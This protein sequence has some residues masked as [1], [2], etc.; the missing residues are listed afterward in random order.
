MVVA[1]GSGATT[2]CV[3]HG[4]HPLTAAE[5]KTQPS[6]DVS[7]EAFAGAVH[8][9]LLSEPSS[10][11]R[12]VRLAGVES[13]QMAR[14]VAKFRG[15]SPERGLAAVT[16]GLYLLRSGELTPRLLGD[17]GPEAL[18]GA[19]HELANAGDEGAAR[20]LYEILARVAPGPE[21]SDARQHLDAIAAWTRDAVATGGPVAAA[22]GLEHVS[23]RRRL[24]EPSAQALDESAN[25]TV[26]WFKK[27]VT[28]Q[29]MAKAARTPPVREEG[30]AAW[31][32]LQT[33]PAVLAA[34]Y[35]RDGDAAGALAAL[36]KADARPFLAKML[37][38]LET[39]IESCAESPDAQ[40]L[41]DVLRAL[42]PLTRVDASREEDDFAE[43]RELFR[44][45][46][47]GVALAAYRLDP[48]LPEAAI[49]VAAYLQELGMAEAGPAILYDAARAHTDAQTLDVA[50]SITLSSLTQES[51]EGDPDAARRTFRAALPLLALADG[52][53]QG[54]AKPKSAILRAV[55][56]DIDLG[57]GRFDE[58]RALFRASAASQKSAAVLLMLAKIDR[59]DGQPQAA[60]ARLREG[61]GAPDAVAD[62]ALRGETLLALSDVL[63]DSGDLAGSRTALV[64]ALRGLTQAR[65][66]GDEKARAGVERVL[67]RVL[68]RFGATQAAQ[69]ALER[70]FAAAPSDKE[71]VVQTVFQMIGRAFVHGDLPAAR[72]GLTRGIAADLDNE[73]LVYFALWVRLL[74][75][76]L[77]AVPSGAPDRIFSSVADDGRWVGR[78]AQFGLGKLRA[79]DLVASATTPSQKS[80]ALFYLAMDRRAS[81]DEKGGNEALKQVVAQ[82]VA[83][84]EARIAA[85]MLRAQKGADNIPLP[86]DVIIP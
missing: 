36:D 24:L 31:R 42:R 75:R 57:E 77:K 34:L 4:A 8:D 41:V 69:R 70:A 35:L 65:T 56:G 14:A 25:D 12:S 53:T 54:G 82:S 18:K 11:E 21:R 86:G 58:A 22:G 79:N 80:E 9:L 61:L 30:F 78:L 37:P 39:A 62:H 16:G 72:D 76:Q 1:L 66:S 45:A 23:V 71:Q 67:S 60:E 74:E 73:D 83:L 50:L 47:L 68:D 51:H 2:A 33:A 26:D 48:T 5:R 46:E 84:E 49:T 44:A 28:L 40:H 19:V 27:A 64:D 10:T 3:N 7:D 6:P 52:R 81:G 43:D 63:H 17:A 29:V 13:R 15:R 55:M 85:E 20:A 59:R 32:A 38:D